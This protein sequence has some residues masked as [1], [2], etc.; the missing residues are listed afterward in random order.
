MNKGGK[1]DA[2]TLK[3]LQAIEECN[4]VSQRYLSRRLG[5]ALGLTN[6]YLKLCVRKGFV[7]FR[8]VPANRYAY[9]LTPKGFSEKSR[10]TAT[11]LSSSFN[12]YREASASCAEL[13]EVCRQNAWRNVLLCGISELTEIA[14]LRAQG[15]EVVLVG[16]YDE[17]ASKATFLTL[18]VSAD[19]AALPSADA[20][21]LCAIH[22]F[23]N[24]F[25]RLKR[26]A[27]LERI[28]VPSILRANGS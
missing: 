10:L 27:P 7:K 8:Q 9:Y 22:S 23:E 13:F 25:A 2:L 21:F 3:L 5:V 24:E 12:F 16:V 26:Y 11:Y 1:E 28:L 18:N 20:F 6:S 14:Y 15:S 17:T 19:I 4:D